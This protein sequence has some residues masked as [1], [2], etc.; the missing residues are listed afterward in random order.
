MSG[1]KKDARP[2]DEQDIF[3][4]TKRA[5]QES[6]HT[7]DVLHG[8]LPRIWQTALDVFEILLQK[9]YPCRE[10]ALIGPFG[11]VEKLMKHRVEQLIEG[12]ETARK[13][14]E[15][16]YQP[17]YNKFVGFSIEH[18]GPNAYK[19]YH[20][21]YHWMLGNLHVVSDDPGW[22][23]ITYHHDGKVAAETKGY[24]ILE[25]ARGLPDYD[26]EPTRSTK[27]ILSQGFKY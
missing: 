15:D 11:H 8:P 4:E 6:A 19:S 20:D 10:V 16:A 23:D 27:V 24:D 25:D 12:K 26:P 5:C 14:I 2:R 21:M 18:C 7:D 22:A 1:V 3:G 17:P 9:G 13:N